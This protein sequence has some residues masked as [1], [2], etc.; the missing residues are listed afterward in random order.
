MILDTHIWLWFLL[1]DRSLSKKIGDLIESQI[2]KCFI[3]SISIWEA[4]ILAER[5]IIDVGKDST[6]VGVRKLLT[7][8]PINIAPI[9]SEIAILSRSLKFTHNDPADRFIAATA[10]VYDLP[11][12]TVDKNL[13]KLNWIKV[14]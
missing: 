10:K 3:S 4:T 14:I 11:L 12:V 7:L 9:N 8:A 6:E 13:K 1:D 2:D 5:K